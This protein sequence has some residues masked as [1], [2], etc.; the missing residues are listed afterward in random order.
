MVDTKAH[1]FFPRAAA[2]PGGAIAYGHHLP[3]ASASAS[4]LGQKVSAGIYFVDVCTPE[5]IT[6]YYNVKIPGIN[7]YSGKLKG[8]CRR[9]RAPGRVAIAFGPANRLLRSG[10]CRPLPVPGLPVPLRS[11]RV[12]AKSPSGH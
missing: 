10:S 11:G 4:L 6:A 5:A 1:H 3:A 2:P 7:T 12:Q 8:A 9:G